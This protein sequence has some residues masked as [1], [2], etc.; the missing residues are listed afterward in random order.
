[1]RERIETSVLLR[2]A[3]AAANAALRVARAGDT[4]ELYAQRRAAR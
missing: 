2:G 4:L 1:M 3:K